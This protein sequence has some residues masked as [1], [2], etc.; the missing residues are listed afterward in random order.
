MTALK[1]NFSKLKGE[2]WGRIFLRQNHQ[3]TFNIY[4]SKQKLACSSKVNGYT[5]IAIM[6][7]Q[8]IQITTVNLHKKIIYSHVKMEERLENSMPLC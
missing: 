1:S 7:S 2:V 3:N 6:K 5:P 4:A 8:Q